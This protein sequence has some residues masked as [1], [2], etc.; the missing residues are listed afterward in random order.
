MKCIDRF[1]LM[2]FYEGVASFVISMSFGIKGVSFESIIVLT[3]SIFPSLSNSLSFVAFTLILFLVTLYKV[4]FSFTSFENQRSHFFSSPKRK[5][6]RSGAICAFQTWS[7][8]LFYGSF[9]T[10]GRI[11]AAA[12]SLHH[13][14]SSRGSE[15]HLQSTPQLI[16]M[17]DP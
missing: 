15:L 14:H 3:S 17:P 9:K 7:F 13:S 11:G 8:C 5:Q 12:A 2:N 6:S 16:A 1:L 10:R 4:I